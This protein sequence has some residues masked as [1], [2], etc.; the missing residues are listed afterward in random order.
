MAFILSLI[1]ISSFAN[2]CQGEF[3]G[4]L[5]LEDK[6]GSF[7][8]NEVL[9]ETNEF[10]KCQNLSFGYTQSAYWVLLPDIY[11]CENETSFVCLQHPSINLVDFYLLK[12]HEIIEE[13]HTGTLRSS[14]SR[15]W[16]PNKFVFPL[17]EKTNGA[18]LL[19]RLQ[20]M[21]GALK[22][23]I[24]YLGQSELFRANLIS[25]MII[26]IFLGAILIQFLYALIQFF[27]QRKK[28]FLWY[29]GLAFCT[30]WFG[31]F[32]LNYGSLI[33][34]DHLIPYINTIRFLPSI[35]GL[36]FLLLFCYELLDVETLLHQWVQTFFKAQIIV[37]LILFFILFLPLPAY[38]VR[39][40][41]MMVF[42]G[43]LVI[44]L[45]TILI[46]A[47]N[48]GIRK[49]HKPAYYFL[50]V[51]SPIAVVFFMY[52]LRNHGFIPE[53]IIFHYLIYFV[54]LFEVLVSLFVM[55]VY[56]RRQQLARLHLNKLDRK[57]NIKSGEEIDEESQQLFLSLQTLFENEKIYLQK[58]L[59]IADVAT[60][61]KTTPH[62]VSKVVNQCG[63]MHFF[64]FVNSFR[65]EHAKKLL[66]SDEFSK[67][68]TIEAIALECG[69]SNRASFNSAFKKFTDT[70]PSA[71]R[72]HKTS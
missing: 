42:Q 26:F 32:S 18:Y 41:L 25:N 63:N 33:L 17:T 19:I 40:I 29:S 24:S 36:I 6:N 2:K 11:Q 50:V 7:S 49:G 12:G 45:C 20:N 15:K 5:I 27:S 58:K 62:L 59:K 64:D 60:R 67:K 14:S 38:P 16:S 72:Q 23:Q 46:T 10:K 31:L 39:S 52:L 4:V 53:H 43:V 9:Q 56:F 71:F 47:G 21:E 57:E 34:P 3:E 37:Y 13:L 70:T 8:L 30:M 22:T 51:Q 65:I 68:Y 55:T 66:L 61:L 1:Y 54:C 35:P 48:T 69:F 28:M 44:S